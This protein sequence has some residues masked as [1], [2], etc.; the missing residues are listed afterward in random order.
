V[1][2]VP[3][4]EQFSPLDPPQ[5]CRF[6]GRCPWAAEEC[7]APVE[8]ADADADA[9]HVVRCVGWFSGRVPEPRSEALPS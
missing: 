7:E 4:G 8:L 1:R 2:A 9:D 6:A 3:K 5:G